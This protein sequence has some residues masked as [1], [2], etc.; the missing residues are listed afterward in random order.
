MPGSC[1]CGGVGRSAE[2]V[3]LPKLQFPLSA[4]PA[5]PDLRIDSR[6]C[7][8]AASCIAAACAAAAAASI[9]IAFSAVITGRRTCCS[10][11]VTREMSGACSIPP[12]GER[13]PAASAASNRATRSCSATPTCGLRSQYKSTAMQL[14]I[15]ILIYSL[16]LS[17]IPLA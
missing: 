10:T 12:G 17:R 15:S 2:Q 7:K 14:I 13:Q 16:Q 5:K 6:C 3:P 11:T 1:C 8:S 9:S 4:I